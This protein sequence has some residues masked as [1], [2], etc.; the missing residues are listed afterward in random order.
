MPLRP[1]FLEG[2]AGPLFAIYHPPEG[3]A[4]DQGDIV[5]VPP[6]AEEMNQSRRMAALQARRFA[7]A[8][9]GV[10]LLD[11]YGT[12]DSS[13]GFED[14]RW[15][16]WCGD[17][18][19]ALDWLEAQGRPPAAL[20]GLRL[21][22]LLAM[23]AARDR[24]GRVT[25]AVLWQPVTKGKTMLTQFLRL[26]V[27]A[28]MSGSGMSGSGARET[29]DALRQALKEGQSIEVA[30][31]RLAPELTAAVDAAELAPLA[32]PA[33]CRVDWLEIASGADTPLSPGAGRIVEAWRTQG[34]RVSTRV[35]TGEPF[36]SMQTLFEPVLVPGLWDQTLAAWTDTPR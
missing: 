36:W 6:F 12:G 4:E 14:A 34:A 25:R 11:L 33:D 27:A 18:A 31:Y 17:V 7:A 20:W 26:R 15:D 28:G 32:P 24:P 3:G 30:G 13:G 1:F 16:I 10:L 8:G 23:A 22:G 2:P 9:L 5:W 21:G 29:T 35:V 19:A